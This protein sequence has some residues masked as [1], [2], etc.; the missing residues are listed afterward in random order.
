MTIINKCKL[1]IIMLICFSL[2]FC[3]CTAPAQMMPEFTLENAKNGQK[4]DS[5]E[6]ADQVR[7][8][9][10]FATWCPPCIKEIPSLV[11]LQ[12]KYKTKGFSVIAI[13]VDESTNAV[14]QIMDKTGINYPVL[15]ANNQIVRDFGGISNIPV[16]FLIDRNGEVV[17]KYTGYV[18]H[19]VLE[20]D[21]LEIIE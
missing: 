7:L 11:D 9:A 17:K 19:S 12:E 21:L 14:R 2:L 20:S 13:S 4:V 16:S 5:S 6:F 18:P 15:M 10:F 8:V 1:S 3:A